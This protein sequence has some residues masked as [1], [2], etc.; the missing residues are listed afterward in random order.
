[1]LLPVGELLGQLA[2]VGMAV[3]RVDITLLLEVHDSVE[4]IEVGQGVNGRLIEGRHQRGAGAQELV[5]VHGG[6][7]SDRVI[8]PLYCRGRPSEATRPGIS[9]SPATCRGRRRL[10]SGRVELLSYGPRRRFHARRCESADTTGR[11]SECRRGR[12]RTAANWPCR[13]PDG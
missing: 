7:S 6:I 13:S 8:S 4:G 10:A 9:E 1:G 12:T 11:R 2:G 3:A 5:L